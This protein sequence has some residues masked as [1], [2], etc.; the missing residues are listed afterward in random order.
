MWVTFFS[1]FHEFNKV[2]ILWDDA[3]K[4]STG[5]L[6]LKVTMSE[7]CSLGKF[8]N[9]ILNACVPIMDLIDWNRSHPNDICNI[10]SMYGI[11]AAWIFFLRVS[12][13][14]SD[15]IICLHDYFNQC[16][17]SVS[18]NFQSAVI[19]VNR[20]W[21]GKECTS[22]TLEHYCRPSFYQWRVLWIE[23][24]RI[25]DAKRL[26][27]KFLTFHFC[28]LFSKYLWWPLACFFNG[29]LITDMII[30]ANLNRIQQ[31][32]SS[33][34]PS[35]IVQIVSMVLLMLFRGEKSL[36]LELVGHLKSYTL[37]R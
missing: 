20:P 37:E 11:T 31:V 10:S 17:F 2:D 29:C 8:W 28:L 26:Y 12:N 18:L 1:G 19:E 36:Q 13:L 23:Q 15:L 34:L 14:L 24:K 27:Y 3:Q 5:E 21:C 35:K 16:H 30:D 33:M 22:R 25:K 7:N 4:N 9:S 6:F 32:A